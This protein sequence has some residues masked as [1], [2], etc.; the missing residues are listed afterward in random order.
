[1]KGQL[2]TRWAGR[3]TENLS[4]TAAILNIALC[5]ANAD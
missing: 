5:F 2:P 4:Q 3:A 1:M